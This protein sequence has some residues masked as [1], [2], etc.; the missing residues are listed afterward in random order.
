ME[1]HTDAEG[2]DR[3]RRK[4]LRTSIV[5]GGGFAAGQIPYTRPET[6]SFFGVRSAWAQASVVYSI[7]C[8][9]DVSL[10]MPAV[11]GTACQNAVLQN[12][13]VQVTPTPPTGT[14]LRCVP[15]TDDPANAGLLPDDSVGT[16]ATGKVTFAD[17]DLTG[18]V[19][20]PPLLVGSV[21]TMT[22]S[23]QNQA[24]FGMASCSNS[25]TISAA[26]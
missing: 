21:L 22:V 15:T 3:V 9:F 19:P 12:I 26:C 4:L 18:N 13:V 2:V 17:F 20:N 24:T 11:P 8:S 5:I 7:S 10:P 16:D 23:F 14:V 1:K 6:K 25:L